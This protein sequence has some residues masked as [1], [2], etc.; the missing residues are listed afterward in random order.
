MF[1]QQAFARLGLKDRAAFEHMLEE[2]L[3]IRMLYAATKR[4]AWQQCV[5]LPQAQESLERG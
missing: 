3:N 5:M 2:W 4:K 1:T